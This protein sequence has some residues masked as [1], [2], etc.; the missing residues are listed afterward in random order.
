MWSPLMVSNIPLRSENQVILV[1]LRYTNTGSNFFWL[2]G[3]FVYRG[4]LRLKK[5]NVCIFQKCL[6]EHVHHT[7]QLQGLLLVCYTK[8]LQSSVYVICS[9]RGEGDS[10]CQ[11][12]VKTGRQYIGALL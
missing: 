7:H 4:D 12:S 9:L 8:K 5:G 2:N 6:S 11:C 1:L 10:Y 3:F